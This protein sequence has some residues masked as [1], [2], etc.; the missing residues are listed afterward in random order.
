MEGFNS[1]A[2]KIVDNDLLGIWEHIDASYHLTLNIEGQDI[3]D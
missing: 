1:S 3:S 2:I